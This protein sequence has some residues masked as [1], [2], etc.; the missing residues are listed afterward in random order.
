MLNPSVFYI[1]YE[2]LSSS[3]FTQEQLTALSTDRLLELARV[4]AADELLKTKALIWLLNSYALHPL[5]SEHLLEEN[6][7]L[8][9][10]PTFYLGDAPV[11]GATIDADSTLACDVVAAIERNISSPLSF[12]AKQHLELNSNLI[13]ASSFLHQYPQTS[14]TCDNEEPN[15][16]SLQSYYALMRL[17]EH[18]YLKHMARDKELMSQTIAP[19]MKPFDSCH[20]FDTVALMLLE[21]VDAHLNRNAAA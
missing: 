3:Y 19:K 16:Q 15:T 5:V 11:I 17:R 13:L 9:I 4:L 10:A 1:S 20:G 14:E 2:K 12:A 21:V 8:Y 6:G 7:K 18:A